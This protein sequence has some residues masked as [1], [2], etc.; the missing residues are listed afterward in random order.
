MMTKILFLEELYLQT[1]NSVILFITV[2]FGIREVN[3][4]SVCFLMTLSMV[5]E[6]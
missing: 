6:C 2:I 5:L 4:F 1:L 3:L